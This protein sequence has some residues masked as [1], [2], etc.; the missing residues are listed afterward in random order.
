MFASCLQLNTTSHSFNKAICNCSIRQADA[1]T[2]DALEQI[3]EVLRLPRRGRGGWT[4]SAETTRPCADLALALN[5][6]LAD[7]G[8]Q[9]SEAAALTWGDV[10]L[11][12]EGTG[13]LTI[14]KGKNQPEPQTVAVTP[15]TARALGE[16]LARRRRPRLSGQ[17]EDRRGP[18]Q[19]VR[20]AGLGDGFSGHSGRTGMA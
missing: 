3:R 6:V 14:Q 18:S 10:K 19:P 12:P 16:N 11:C 20:A 2:T 13:S 8:L 17:P 15:A 9:R 7:G 4:E 5:R 1:L